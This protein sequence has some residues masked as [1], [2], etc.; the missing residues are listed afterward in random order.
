MCTGAE[1]VG[2]ALSGGGLLMNQMNQNDAAENQQRILSQAQ[3]EQSRLN[4]KK[5][6]TITNF[7]AETFNPTTRDQKYEQAAVKNESS[8]KDA[9]LSASGGEGGE[10]YG[11]T[12]GNLSDDYVRGKAKATADS[13]TDIANRARLLARS[14]AA[15]NMYNDESLAGANLASDVLGINAAGQR[16]RSATNSA[17]NAQNNQGSMLAGLLTTAGMAAPGVIKNNTWGGV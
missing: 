8:L 17:L 14:N 2:L 16:T 9:L 4:G 7:A 11:G 6:D 12:Q 1:I 5:A 3:E 10:V 15:G 13:A